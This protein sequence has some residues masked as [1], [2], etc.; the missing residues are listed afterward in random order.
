[1]ERITVV[2]TWLS[3]TLAASSELGPRPS[4]KCITLGRF[5]IEPKRSLDFCKQHGVSWSCCTPIIDDE[6]ALLFESF[7]ERGR[8]C[9]FG[10]RGST[11]Q[12]QDEF[13]QWMCL[14]CDANQG[15]YLDANG[16]LRVCSTFAERFF[17]GKG[18]V[19]NWNECGIRLP[20]LCVTGADHPGKDRFE[21]G[22]D[23][24]FPMTPSWWPN[25]TEMMKSPNLRPFGLDDQPIVVVKQADLTGD[26]MCFNRGDR[27]KPVVTLSLLSLMFYL[28]F[29]MW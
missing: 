12:K 20:E 3:L 11:R 28:A 16:N 2:T 17:E 7:L 4:K 26:E 8:A 10:I 5:P 15:S 22:D 23:P 9:P 27:N 18:D 24:M 6:V 21:C 1:M 19:S 29:V 14:S 13:M 25:A